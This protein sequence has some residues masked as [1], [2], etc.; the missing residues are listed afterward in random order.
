MSKPKYRSEIELAM[1][2]NN[3]TWSTYLLKIML[4]ATSLF[5]WKGLDEAAGFGATR[6]LE[7]ALFFQGMGCFVKDN[8]KGYLALRVVQQGRPNIYGQVTRYDAWGYGFRLPRRL[9][10]DDNTIIYN[11]TLATPTVQ[12][13]TL[14]AKRLYEIDRTMD[15][16]VKAQKTPILLETDTTSRLT[17]KQVYE[18]YDGNVPFIMGNKEFGLKDKVRCVNTQAPYVVDKLD[19][20]KHEIW[21]EL[22]SVLGVPNTDVRKKERLVSSEANGNSIEV[23]LF[24]ASQLATRKAAAADIRAKFGLDIE[25]DLKDLSI[26]DS[27]QERAYLFDAPQRLSLKSGEEGEDK[28]NG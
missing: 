20:H 5:E 25:V 17:L 7:E 18:Q 11:N 22:L 2:E 6:F 26:I 3:L 1:A 13:I 14:Y 10:D 12:L 15:V 9:G 19:Q 23:N 21:N 4:L 16:N 28:N 24:L 8:T 27:L